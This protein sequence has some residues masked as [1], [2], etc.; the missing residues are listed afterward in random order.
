ML[1]YKLLRAA[2]WSELEAAGTTA[3]APIDRA[4]G[5]IHFSTAE[6]L[7]GTLEKHFAGER[8]LM[9]LAVDADGLGDALVWEPSRGGELFPHL[10]RL[11]ARDDVA[12]VRRLDAAPLP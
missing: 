7:P 1:I 2:E 10:Y 8:D 11:L 12:W 6:Q 3:G 5:Y 4:D 9:L